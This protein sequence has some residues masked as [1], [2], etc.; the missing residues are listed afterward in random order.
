[1]ELSIPVTVEL[2]GADPDL[3]TSVA[4]G[5][6]AE[7]MALLD[8]L[9]LPGQPRVRVA[10][11]TSTRVVRFRVFGAVRPYSRRL[12]QRAWRAV[13]PPERHD[14]P[15]PPGA[16][17]FPDAWMPAVAAGEPELMSRFV[18]RLGLE[19]IK[20]SPGCLVGPAQA[21][22]YA[23]GVR[24]HA[25]QLTAALARI[26][27]LG[28]S[29]RDR[30]RVMETLASARHL[31]VSLDDGVEA[32]FERLRS[33]EIRVSVPPDL[34]S[35][36][37]RQQFPILRETL[38]AELGIASRLELAAERVAGETELGI[39][40]NDQLSVMPVLRPDELLLDEHPARLEQRGLR[41][42]PFPNPATRE[43][44]T[45]V[46]AALLP[47]VERLRIGHWTPAGFLALV[48]YAEVRR[49][50]HRAIGAEDVQRRLAQI[51]EVQPALVAA[52]LSRFTAWDVVRV[53][54]GLASEGIAPRDLELILQRM[55]LLDTLPVEEAGLLC[56]DDRP[57]IG[58]RD[59]ERDPAALLRWVRL[60]LRRQVTEQ[61][62]QGRRL[63]VALRLPADAEARLAGG[64]GAA[65]GLTEAEAD[66]VLDGLW[67]DL[68]LVPAGAEV[69][70]VVVTSARARAGVRALIG[71]ELPET[72]VIAEDEVVPGFEV[73][74]LTAEGEAGLDTQVAITAERVGRYLER[75]AAG[76]AIEPAADGFDV[77]VGGGPVRVAVTGADGRTIVEVT[78]VTNR[79]VP[80]G[81]PL[82]RWLAEHGQDVRFAHL[83]CSVEG[84]VATVRCRY[85]LLGDFLDY[86]ELRLAV[87]AVAAAGAEA[88]SLIHARFGGR[89]AL[90]G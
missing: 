34:L 87:E 36:A 2:Q 85:A 80:A 45:A 42:R 56:C 50:A 74:T 65:S 29:L 59:P 73:R 52:A 20:T 18:C 79:D 44:C 78:S 21:A 81:E 27:D 5:L 24:A 72:C 28:L 8:G 58:E 30:R 77:V 14:L 47:E 40:I 39:R 10:G 61:C 16:R 82:F 6:S 89:P 11:G 69:N 63:L 4:G 54:R 1:M 64:G 19:A 84:E 57:P 17:G 60:G 76:T 86:E 25:D 37:V 38:A 7:L 35:G 26:L 32:V 71:D 51:E 41:G 23:P 43:D 48:V 31:R 49:L 9:G 67:D 13:A 75:L 3:G 66:R 12:M 88:G 46:P 33:D 83:G 15:R 53:A 90:E 70:P 68:A 62:A 22:A 55:V